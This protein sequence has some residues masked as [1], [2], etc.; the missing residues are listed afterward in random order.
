MPRHAE[1]GLVRAGKK[2]E[3]KYSSLLRGFI[4]H[5]PRAPC[6]LD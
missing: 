1:V 6:D 5:I 2:E 3:L 4:D